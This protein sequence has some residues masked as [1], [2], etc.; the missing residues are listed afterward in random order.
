[1]N[2]AAC[3]SD[4]QKLTVVAVKVSSWNRIYTNAYVLRDMLKKFGHC[5]WNKVLYE[6][7]GYTNLLIVVLPETSLIGGMALLFFSI[8]SLALHDICLVVYWVHLR[9]LNTITQGIYLK[10][11]GAKS[12]F[13]EVFRLYLEISYGFSDVAD[14]NMLHPNRSIERRGSN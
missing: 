10:S 5:L 13:F 12:T 9:C 4:E 3:L 2:I 14:N 8:I 7:F 11:F 6:V 1:M